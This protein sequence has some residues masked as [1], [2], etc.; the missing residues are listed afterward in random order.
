MLACDFFSFD[1]VLLRRFY[2]LFFIEL[3]TRRVYMTGVNANPTGSWVVRQARNLSLVLADR[4]HP[5][6]LLIRDRDAKFSSSFDEVFKAEHVRIICTPVRAPQAN[7]YAERFVGTIRRECLDRMLILGR[8][9]LEQVLADYVAHYNG[10]RPHRALGQQD[11]VTVNQPPPMSDPRPSQ[12]R[13]PEAV[14]G[15]IH[16]YLLVA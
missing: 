11:P 6:R 7:A 5:V 4:M 14:S 2:V 9:H 8:R 15:P 12:L 3:D 16:E 1:T 10:Y 13:K